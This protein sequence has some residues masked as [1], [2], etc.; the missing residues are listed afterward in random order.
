MMRITTSLHLIRVVLVLCERQVSLKTLFASSLY[1]MRHS[2]VMN[3]YEKVELSAKRANRLFYQEI[4]SGLKYY[5]M[6]KTCF[7]TFRDMEDKEMRQ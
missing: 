1:E 2:R 5:Y 7:Y 6:F 4:Y 3:L